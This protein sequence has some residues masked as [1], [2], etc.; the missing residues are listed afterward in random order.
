MSAPL[1][2]HVATADEPIPPP[3]ERP[4]RNEPDMRLVT[5]LETM[6]AELAHAADDDV[7]FV[8]LFTVFVA[9]VGCSLLAHYA[10]DGELG[11]TMGSPVDPQV[12]HRSRW[13]HYLV[14][15]LDAVES[16]RDLLLRLLVADGLV[17]DERPANPRETTRAVRDW[18]RAGGRLLL[19][20]E[21]HLEEGNG[22]PQALI[23]GPP[24]AAAEC[25]RAGRAYF[26]ARHRWRADRQIKRVVRA[27]GARTENGW[28]V[29]EGAAA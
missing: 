15:R 12:R 13:M 1:P 6:L 10:R 27:L 4:L 18:L 19:T 9:E 11:L 23:D 14:D 8:A 25:R 24:D 3:S 17:W 2:L 22:V 29:L 20:P 16:R 26:E 21:G 7:E 28:T 5:P